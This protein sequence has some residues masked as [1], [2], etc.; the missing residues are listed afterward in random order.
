MSSLALPANRVPEYAVVVPAGTTKAAPYSV[1]MTF[2][3]AVVSGIRI[4]IPDGHVFL[5]GLQL[6]YSGGQVIPD[7]AGTWISG[8][9]DVIDLP[10]TGYP[11]GGQWSAQ[12]Y[13]TGQF[14]HTFYVLFLLNDQTLFGPQPSAPVTQVPALV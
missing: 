12:A 10:L 9:D 5:T 2:L 4:R 3:Q 11:T 1:D 8:N 6:L 14:P 13:N 7:T